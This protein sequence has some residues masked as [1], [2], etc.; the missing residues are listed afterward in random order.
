MLCVV[1]ML[2]YV[3]I[4]DV[5]VVV[6]CCIL[7]DAVCCYGAGLDVVV[8]RIGG[9]RDD[10]SDVSAVVGPVVF[11][12]CVVVCCVVMH[13]NTNIIWQ[14]HTPVL[15][16]TPRFVPLAST[17]CNKCTTCTNTTIENTTNII[18]TTTTH[19]TDINTTHTS[20]IL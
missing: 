2:H 19:H 18:R 6:L 10:V 13:N 9:V 3:A 15:T 12:T 16:L 20:S 4:C 17:I 11:A 14:L 5:G 1:T 8:V 7:A